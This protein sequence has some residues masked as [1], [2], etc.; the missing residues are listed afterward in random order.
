[1]LRVPAGI[2]SLIIEDA[3]GAT[4]GTMRIR[5][6]SGQFAPMT[7]T[8]PTTS[9][10]ILKD[11]AATTVDVSSTD[12]AFTGTID[13]QVTATLLNTVSTLPEDTNT[14]AAIRVADVQVN[15]FAGPGQVISVAGTHAAL[16]EVSGGSVYLKAGSS[17]DFETQPLLTFEVRVTHPNGAVTALPFALSISDVADDSTAPT[18]LITALPAASTTRTLNIAV[19][20]N[21]PGLGASGILEY[22]LYYST[23]G[24]FVKFATVPAGVAS[25][26]FTGTANTTYWFRSVARDNA[27]N[28]ETKI[29]ADTYTRIGDVVPPSTQVTTAVP[30]SSGL[31]TVQMTGNKPSGTPITAFDV[32]VVIDSGEPILIGAASSVATGGGN[33]SGV[34]LFQGILD[35]V[36]R[37]YRFYSRGRDGAGNVETAPVSGGV[38]A[39]YSFA[40]AGL[41]ATAIDVQNGVNQ[42]SYVRY[43]DVLFSTSTGLGD[44]LAAGRVMVERFGIDATAVDAGTGVAVTG[45][46]LVQNGNKLRLDFGS[47]G[48]GGLRQA[49]NGFYRVLLDLDGNGTFTDAGDKAFEF[50][51][52]FGDANGDAKVDVADTNLVTSQIGR[53]GTNL[54]GDLD[55]N[56]S[57][58]S[59]DRLYT[60]QQRGKKLLE[61][62]V[63]WLDD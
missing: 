42:R 33:Y 47:N 20:G 63:S 30:T 37:T 51:R 41:T 10:V 32:Y 34:I 22:D 43:L 25:T 53:V 13:Q 16:F 28:V 36:S 23:G 58:N 54:D 46:G 14:T 15:A 26:T 11:N 45:F 29:S 2:T 1:M 4:E 59:T 35:G 27:G 52:L 62:L 57:V 19:T 38:S 48:I 18:S 55:G 44:L 24:S 5:S 3:D 9:L 49:G 7:F 50:H 61:P 8:N 12:T 6:A 31:F 39:T 17:L 60:T 56:G 40:S 21:D